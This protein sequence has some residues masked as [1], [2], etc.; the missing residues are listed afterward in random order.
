MQPWKPS[1]PTKEALRNIQSA[2]ASL[3]PLIG[4]AQGEDSDEDYETDEEDSDEDEEESKE[5]EKTNSE[6]KSKSIWVKATDRDTGENLALS[7]L[8]R[9]V[10]VLNSPQENVTI[11]TEQRRRLDGMN[12][13]RAMRTPVMM[14]TVTAA[15]MVA[16]VVSTKVVA[17]LEHKSGEARKEGEAFQ[18]CA[19]LYEGAIWRKRRSFLASDRAKSRSMCVRLTSM[20]GHRSDWPLPT[21]LI[22]QWISSGS[23]SSAAQIR[24]S[25]CGAVAERKAGQGKEGRQEAKLKRYYRKPRG[26]VG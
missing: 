16:I 10:I 11:I 15:E 25:R 23:Y 8:H 7:E 13:V 17:K 14:T 3:L 5:Q 20:D 12:P 1:G 2:P 18:P 19:P 9:H 26:R 22:R 6:A 4:T 21:R 24:T